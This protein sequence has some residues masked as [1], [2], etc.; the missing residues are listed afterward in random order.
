MAT[1]PT[2]IKK[3]N[4]SSWEEAY[5]K[6][7]H[8]QLVASGTADSTTFLRGD[9][10]WA[11]INDN[12]TKNTAGSTDTASKIFLV[13]ATSQATNPQTFSDNE[14]YVT[15]GVLTTKE[16]QV[17]GTAATMRYNTTTKSIEFIFA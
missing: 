12:D 16:V 13:G 5:P 9:G 8:T 3:W 14:V 2:I 6:T 11:T 7:T 10:V 4:G 17:G 15:S 1:Y